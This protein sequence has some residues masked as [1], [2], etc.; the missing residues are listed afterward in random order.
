MVETM[1]EVRAFKHRIYC[2]VCDTELVMLAM[3]PTSP[4]R[5]RY[6]CPKCISPTV[7]KDKLYPYY[8]YKEIT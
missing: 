1:V 6:E 3:L 5:Y 2:N 8:S 4:P 7:V